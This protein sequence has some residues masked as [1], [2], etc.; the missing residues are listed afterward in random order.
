MDMLPE[1]RDMLR[2]AYRPFNAWLHRIRA[3]HD[4]YVPDWIAWD[5]SPG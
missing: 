5:E 2:H 3:F 1:T 4:G